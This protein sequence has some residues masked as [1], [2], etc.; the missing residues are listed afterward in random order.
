M[1]NAEAAMPQTHLCVVRVVR[2][3]LLRISQRLPATT[4]QLEQH[5]VRATLL[6]AA[7]D[8]RADIT[9]LDAEANRA[10]AVSEAS[11]QAALARAAKPKSV[12]ARRERLNTQQA[13]R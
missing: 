6:R 9:A 1:R 5:A 2:Q 4:R 10:S 8:Q 13:N 3:Q 7:V 12:C 11:L